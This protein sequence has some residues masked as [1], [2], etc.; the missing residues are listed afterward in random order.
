MEVT[1]PAV[2][3]YP[4]QLEGRLGQPSRWLWLVKWLLAVPHFVVLAFLPPLLWIGIGV[5]GGGAL[6]L[7]LGAGGMYAAVHRSPAAAS[8]GRS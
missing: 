6:V 8:P 7:L 3:A 5:L 2:A 4:V 1:S